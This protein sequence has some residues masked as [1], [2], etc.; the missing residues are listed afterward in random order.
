MYISFARGRFPK[1]SS[2]AKD[3]EMRLKKEEDLKM[4]DEMSV[5]KG[6]LFSENRSQVQVNRDPSC[7]QDKCNICSFPFVPK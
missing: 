2:V 7:S 6:T 1:L 5:E 4:I 3:I